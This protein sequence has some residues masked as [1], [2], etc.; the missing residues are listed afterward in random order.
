MVSPAYRGL[1]TD[2]AEADFPGR[3]ELIGAMQPLMKA[4]RRPLAPEWERYGLDRDGWRQLDLMAN[5]LVR[6]VYFEHLGR[7]RIRDGLH[8][9]V[10]RY[11]AM[12][13]SD[14]PRR[15][16]FAART[17]DAMA[18]EPLRGTV[19]LGVEHLQLPDGTAVG[20]VRFVDPSSDAELSEAL[21]RFGDA[22]PALLCEVDVEVTAGTSDLLRDRARV[23]AET[24]LGLVRQQNLFGFAAKIYREQ[25]L[26]GLD[27]TW[28]LRNDSGVSHVG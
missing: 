9:T 23:L 14:R 28:A 25:V 16:N 2:T 18:Q 12:N 20:D 1:V 4:A 3:T 8:D 19:Y 10:K 15:R 5:R 21:A 17:L 7:E 27:G 13:P 24:A 11:R 26:Y 6:H 22:A